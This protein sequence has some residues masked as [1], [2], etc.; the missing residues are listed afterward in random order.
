MSCASSYSIRVR[1]WVSRISAATLIV[2]SGLSISRSEERRVGKECRYGW[3]ANQAEDGIRDWSVTGVQ[4]CALPICKVQVI[5]N[6]TREKGVT[7]RIATP[8]GEGAMRLDELRILVQHQS[9]RMGFQDL[10]RDADRIQRLV[11]I[12]IGRASCRERV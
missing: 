3:A 11:H 7:L 6:L 4:T 12:E 2:Y 9:A 8:V 1:G 5:Q 10:S